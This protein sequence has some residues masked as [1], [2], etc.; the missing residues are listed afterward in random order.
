MVKACG[1]MRKFCEDTGRSQG[2]VS[3]WIRGV[4]EPEPESIAGMEKDLKS[5]GV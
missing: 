2:Q 3:D 1:S 5:L 4:K